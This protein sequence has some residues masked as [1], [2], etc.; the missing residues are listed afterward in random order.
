M[1]QVSYGEEKVTPELQ[2]QIANGGVGSF[3]NMQN[4]DVV[5]EVQKIS[6]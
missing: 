6:M 3:L 1:Q 2:K 4:I 5:N